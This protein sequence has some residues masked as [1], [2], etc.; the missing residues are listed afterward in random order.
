VVIAHLPQGLDGVVPNAPAASSQT[1]SA[2]PV[3]RGASGSASSTSAASDA[4]TGPGQLDYLRRLAGTIA[5]LR[6]ASRA[7]GIGRES[8]ATSTTSCSSC[9]AAQRVPS[10]TYFTFDMDARF[11]EQ[12]NLKTTRQLIVGSSLGLALRPELQG[13]IPPFRDTYQSTTSFATMLAVHRFVDSESA[14]ADQREGAVRQGKDTKSPSAPQCRTERTRG[15]PSPLPGSLIP[16]NRSRRAFNGPLTPGFSRSA[17]RG[18][19][20]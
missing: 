11:L 8:A 12:R 17:A 19:S 20:T 7:P 5:A 16:P 18:N 2:S 15:R 14:N 6:Q 3:A 1:P 9:S 13:D 10:A 4:A